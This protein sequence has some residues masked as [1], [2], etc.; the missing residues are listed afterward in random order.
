VVLEVGAGLGLLSLLAAKAGAARVI[1]LELPGLAE[2][3]ERVASSNTSRVEVVGVLL[4]NL[5]FQPLLLDPSP[6]GCPAYNHGCTCRLC[7]ERAALAGP[8]P[9]PC[10]CDL[11]RRVQEQRGR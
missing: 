4:V 5:L 11:C 3:T 2:L 7:L 8:A 10:S 9:A 6:G 1:A